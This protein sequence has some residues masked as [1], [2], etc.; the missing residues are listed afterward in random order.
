MPT[1]YVPEVTMER[2]APMR[3][4]STVSKNSMPITMSKLMLSIFVDALEP[5]TPWSEDSNTMIVSAP[6][7]NAMLFDRQAKVLV[8]VGVSSLR[9]KAPNDVLKR[10]NGREGTTRWAHSNS[11]RQFQENTKKER[12]VGRRTLKS[13]STSPSISQSTKMGGHTYLP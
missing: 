6:R 4:Y 7:E 2:Y 11:D 13:A 8:P 1:L 3:R 9:P 10:G 5:V 12:F